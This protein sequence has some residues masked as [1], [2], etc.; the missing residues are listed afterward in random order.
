LSPLSHLH[1]GAHI[2]CADRDRH[3]CDFVVQTLRE[4]GHCVFQATDGLAAL[5]LCLS[6]RT[7]DLLITDTH[8][9]GLNGAELIRQVREQLP[10]LP[11]MYVKNADAEHAEV[12]VGLPPDVP[13]LRDPF[14]AQ[15]LLEA[16][17]P[18]VDGRIRH[19]GRR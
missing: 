18:L 1:G 17:R 2:V 15:E 7:V 19:D 3:L 10:T 13:I 12:P 4:A 8:M 9:P 6:L 16:V 5:E 11:I 14:S